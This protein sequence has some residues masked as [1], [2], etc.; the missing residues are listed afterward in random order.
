MV[1]K[2]EVGRYGDKERYPFEKNYPQR[3]ILRDKSDKLS[4]LRKVIYLLSYCIHNILLIV[5]TRDVIRNLYL[6]SSNLQA[7]SEG[8]IFSQYPIYT[9]I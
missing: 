3:E 1:L 9:C 6:N 2:C 8:L 5:P 4:T 7:V